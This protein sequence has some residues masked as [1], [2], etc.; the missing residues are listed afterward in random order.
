MGGQRHKPVHRW[1]H[2]VFHSI[3]G[4]DGG[5]VYRVFSRWQVVA[6]RDVYEFQKALPGQHVHRLRNAA[7]THPGSFMHARQTEG[8]AGIL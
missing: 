4:T 6:E 2:R 8:E 7:F 1:R 5:G 3:I